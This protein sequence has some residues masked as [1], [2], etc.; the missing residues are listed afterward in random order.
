MTP[1]TQKPRRGRP[2]KAGRENL[3]TRDALIRSGTAILTEQG[4]IAAGIDA[5]LRQV[6]VPKGSFYY[7]FDSKEAFGEAIIENYASFFA[8]MLDKHL[9]NESLAP[10]DRLQA[11]VADAARGMAKYQFRRGC[12]IGNLGQEVSNLPPNYRQQLIAILQSWERRV[13]ECLERARQQNTLAAQADCRELAAYFWAGWE[14]AVMRA[15]LN[16]NA[17]P[18]HNFISYFLGGLPRRTAASV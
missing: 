14:G 12:L 2:P 5:I 16:A 15:K 3:D 7:Y 9:L 1:E 8:H 6:G 17:D 18:L 10:L 11:F 13:E 4:F